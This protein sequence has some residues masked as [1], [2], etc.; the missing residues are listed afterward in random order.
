[1]GGQVINRVRRSCYKRGRVCGAVGGGGVIN[2]GVDFY[3]TTWRPT[4]RNEL[5]G[6]NNNNNNNYTIKTI[7][8][9]AFV[10]SDV[11]YGVEKQGVYR[12]SLSRVSFDKEYNNIT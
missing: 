12:F 7:E 6:E 2:R 5:H 11:R 9:G 10:N 4:I 8:S 1:M 3:H